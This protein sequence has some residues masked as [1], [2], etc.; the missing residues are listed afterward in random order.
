MSERTYHDAGRHGLHL[1]LDQVHRG[2]KELLIN[3]GPRDVQ[4]AVEPFCAFERRRRLFRTGLADGW[5][6]KRG[7]ALLGDVP[8]EI[9]GGVEEGAAEEIAE[10][11]CDGIVQ[12]GMSEK[13]ERNHKF[14]GRPT[15]RDDAERGPQRP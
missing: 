5:V 14:R 9:L 4:Q 15:G 8:R 3:D 7:V 10:E 1:V 6:E 11:D 13:V 2:R 12:E